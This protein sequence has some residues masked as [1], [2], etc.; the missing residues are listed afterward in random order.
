LPDV[1]ATV[2]AK[3]ATAKKKAKKRRR[4]KK[5]PVML[6]SGRIFDLKQAGVYLG[7][8]FWSVR[9]FILQRLIPVVQMPPL[10]PREGARQA[11][12]SL[13]RVLIDRQDLDKFI[14]ERKRT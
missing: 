10:T 3:K 6:P 4:S 14:E 2:A 7:V 8:S 12:P 11:G 9:D 13:R 1:P 5:P